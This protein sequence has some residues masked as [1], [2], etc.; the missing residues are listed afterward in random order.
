[1]KGK[2]GNKRQLLTCRG[3]AVLFVAIAVTFIAVTPVIAQ[4]EAE[5][6]VTVNA[7][8]YV[9]AGETFDVTIDVEGITD[10]NSGMFDLTFD[11]KVVK[12]DDVTDGIIDDTE[13]PAIYS[14]MDSDTIRVI[15]ELSGLTTVSDSGYLAVITFK[16]KGDAGDESALELSGGELTKYVFDDERATPEAIE[17]NNWNGAVVKVGAEE[18]EKEEEEEEEPTATPEA[19]VTE[20]PTSEANVTESPTSE[21]NVTE[22]ST[23]DANVTE[24]PTP[25]LAPEETPKPTATPEKKSTPKPTATPEKK[26]TPTPTPVPGFEAIFAIA[27]MSAI[28]YILLRKKGGRSE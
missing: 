23:S 28:A 22:S 17:V 24:S 18:E 16:V 12:V 10:F 13:I 26:S 2:V 7:P 21:A 6:T 11:H 14:P 15:S 27:M 3:I 4:E 19:N 5:V 9:E 8:E 20:S 1:M 25:T